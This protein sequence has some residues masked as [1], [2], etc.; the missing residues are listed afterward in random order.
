MNL[1]VTCEHAS[2]RIPS[3]LYPRCLE[4]FSKASLDTHL[5]YDLHAATAARRLARAK[6]AP[7]LLG[8]WSRLCIDLNRSL[9]NPSVWSS[10]AEK[11][12]PEEKEFLTEYY[13][14]YRAKVEDMI[15]K[16]LDGGQVLH[17]SVHSFAPEMQ[18]IQRNCDIGWLYDPSR[19]EEKKVACDFQD[20]LSR[21][22]WKVRRNYPYRGIA[23]GLTTYLRRNFTAGE[24]LGLELEL[25]QALGTGVLKVVDH[26]SRDMEYR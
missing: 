2:N 10:L 22:G 24:Y 17:I 19:P 11:M 26:L 12:A 23:D 15:R 6:Q 13:S 1:I 14:G 16:A 8:K 18:G 4:N 5:A 25:N 9:R 3:G 21:A 20:T 7:I